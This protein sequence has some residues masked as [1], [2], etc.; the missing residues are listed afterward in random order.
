MLFD[1]HMHTD[2][3]KH[4]EGYLWEYVDQGKATGLNGVIFTCHSPMPNQFSSHV[5][6][7]PDEIWD[8]IALVGEAKDSAPEGFEVRLGLESDYFPGMETWLQQLHGTA[9]FHYILGSVHWHLPEYQ[10]AFYTGDMWAFQCQY[11]EHLALSAESG[12]FDCI[13]H[14]DLVKNASPSDW[15]LARTVPVIGQVLDRIA[16]T[17]VAMELNTSGIHKAVPEMN[18]GPSFLA[19]MKQR[20]IPVVLGSDAHQPARVGESF[21]EAL[22][23]LE[24]A[25]YDKISSFE[26]RER[27]EMDIADAKAQLREVEVSNA[28]QNV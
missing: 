13:A 15:D 10:A 17:G 11:F 23:M 24:A 8:Y 2:L 27:R 20:D 14:P 19:L 7:D 12:L 22:K 18:P 16:A 1:S 4:A 25:G 9:D 3:C 6:M 5:R 26:G 21:A 28:Q